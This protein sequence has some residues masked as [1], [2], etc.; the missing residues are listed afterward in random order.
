M[1]QSI[2]A[3]QAFITEDICLTMRAILATHESTRRMFQ[4]T[5]ETEAYGEG[6]RDAVLL[7][8]EALNVHLGIPTAR[9]YLDR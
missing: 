1:P 3:S 2:A 6:F 4:E 8:A 7:L 5:P 9:H